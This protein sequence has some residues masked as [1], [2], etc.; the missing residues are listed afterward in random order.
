MSFFIKQQTRNLL[1][2]IRFVGFLV[3]IILEF[4]RIRLKVGPSQTLRGLNWV[5]NSFESPAPNF[6]KWEILKKWGSDS[7]WIE[8]GTYLGETT[9]VL[10]SFAR[11]VITI[12]PAHDLALDA[13]IKFGKK[14]NVRVIEGTSED[15]LDGAIQALLNLKPLDINFWLDGHYS[16]GI[17]YLGQS[18]CPVP[19]ELATIEKYLKSDSKLTILID[20]VRAFSPTG[21]IRSGYPSLSYLVDWAD[22]NQLRWTIEHDIFVMTNRNS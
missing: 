9:Q 21:Q 12:E 17:T 4:N 22:R 10:S 8:T 11:E 1:T 19:E 18:E 13:R 7:N 14:G 15:V 3:D 5:R 16:A 6:V 2:Q 20:D